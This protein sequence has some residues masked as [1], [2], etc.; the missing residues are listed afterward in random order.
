MI[1]YGE[2]DNQ[3]LS[4]REKGRERKRKEK[5]RGWKRG[6]TDTSTAFVLWDNL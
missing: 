2:R 3:R 6:E 4:D 5:E 1:S